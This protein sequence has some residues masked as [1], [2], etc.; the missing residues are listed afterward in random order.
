MNN[1]DLINSMTGSLVP[2]EEVVGVLQE[3]TLE[4]ASCL[5]TFADGM[6]IRL[7]QPNQEVVQGL[8]GAIGDR[9]SILRTDISNKEYL[10]D[11]ERGE[12]SGNSS[13][14]IHRGKAKT[15]NKQRSLNLSKNQ[16]T[17]LIE[18]EKGCNTNE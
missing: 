2:W 11:I 8:K 12:A 13:R 7:A 14:N 5:V 3:V 18:S 4:G 15:G 16:R 10:F 17:L 6:K 1:N 9:T